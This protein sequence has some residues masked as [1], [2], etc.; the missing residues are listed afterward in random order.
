MAD[1]ALGIGISAVFGSVIEQDIDR[2]ERVNGGDRA[3]PDSPDS[4]ACGL[5][6]WSVEHDPA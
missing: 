3:S 6:V 2:A 1:L 5:G 4:P